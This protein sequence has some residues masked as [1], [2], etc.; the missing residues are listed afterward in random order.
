MTQPPS[1]PPQPHN[2]LRAALERFGRERGR[3]Q[4]SAAWPVDTTAAS[5]DEVER[6][7]R[8]NST[9][10]GQGQPQQEPATID[11]EF[12]SGDA[13]YTCRI[14]GRNIREHELTDEVRAYLEQE[15]ACPCLH[16]GH[17]CQATSCEDCLRFNHEVF[18][19]GTQE[20]QAG[21]HVHERGTQLP[22]GS[23]EELAV[24]ECATC[25]TQMIGAA[26]SAYKQGVA[27]GAAQV[28]ER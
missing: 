3:A 13:P 1:G 14:C 27:D 19:L 12:R 18:V 20:R 17:E 26:W 25:P 11:H 4:S 22:M 28:K 2:P 23:F 8:T 24:Y 16:E 21:G 7:R 5:P 15:L 9:L 10:R 6:R